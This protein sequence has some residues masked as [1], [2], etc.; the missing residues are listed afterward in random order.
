MH[1]YYTEQTWNDPSN[2]DICIN[3]DAIGI[4]NAVN[5]IC[6]FVKNYN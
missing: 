2:Y 5:L 6:D 4:D 1:E 3:S